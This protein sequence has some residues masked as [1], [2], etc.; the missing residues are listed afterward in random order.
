MIATLGRWHT[1]EMLRV[2]NDS[3]RAYADVLPADCYHEP[4][5]ER[6]ELER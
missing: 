2:V 4:Y 5:M 3:A 1:D 6:A